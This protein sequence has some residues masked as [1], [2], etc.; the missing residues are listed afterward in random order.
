MLTDD[1]LI[2]RLSADQF[3]ALLPREAIAESAAVFAR[4]MLDLIGRPYVIHGIKIMVGASVGLALA[5]RDGDTAD[6]LLGTADFAQRQAKAAG[7]GTY[8]AFDAQVSARA[9]ARHVMAGDLH[10]AV[11]ASEFVLNYQGLIQPDNF[12]PLSEETGLIEPIGE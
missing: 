8:R 12:I 7:R 5:P 1:H 2:A 10:R 11:L 3:A 4:R 6:A 9:R